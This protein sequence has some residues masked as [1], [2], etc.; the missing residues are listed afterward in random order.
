MSEPTVVMVTTPDGEMPAH[1]WLPE[2]GSG[3]GILLVQ[4]IFGISRYVRQ[5][6]SDLA[7]QGYVVLA[8]EIFWRLGVSAVPEGPGALEEAMAVAGRADWD[9]AVADARAALAALH[10]REEVQGAV[11]LVGFCFGGGLAFHVA[12]LTPDAEIDALVSYYGSATAEHLDLAPDV[13]VPSLHHYGLADSFVPVE[14]VER[15]AAAVDGP[16]AQLRTYDGADHAFDNPDLPF[17]H[18][19]ASAAAW[20]HT[21]EFLARHLHP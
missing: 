5:R 12:A 19:Q 4:E 17:H 10:G 13:T 14:T 20:E 2:G 21:R 9:E 15:I 3:P 1:L 11:G 7:E 6:A 8:P 18:P 16:Q